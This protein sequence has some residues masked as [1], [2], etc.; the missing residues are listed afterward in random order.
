MVVKKPVDV[1]LTPVPQVSGGE[2]VFNVVDTNTVELAE[3]LQ[4]TEQ[5]V[6]SVVAEAPKVKKIL[7][8]K[9]V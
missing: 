1:V 6:V 8:K 3:V 5:S 2:T 9:T 4:Q 7:K